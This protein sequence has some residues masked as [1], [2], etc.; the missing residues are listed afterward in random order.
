[1]N[2]PTVHGY[3]QLANSY[4]FF[5]KLM[6]GS[7][8][9]NARTALLNSIPACRSALILGDGNGRL[10]DAL[11]SSQPECE[12]TSIDQSKKMLDIQQQ[13]LS[14]H[15]LRGNVTWRH[16]D[17]RSFEGFENQFDLLVSAFFLDCFTARDL[18][19]HLPRWLNSLRPGG[20]FYFVDFQEPDSGWKRM[21]GKLCLTAMHHFFRWQTDLPNRTLVNMNAALDQCALEML[22]SQNMSH[23]LIC[24]RLYRV[25][26]VEEN[27]RSQAGRTQEKRQHQSSEE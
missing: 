17:A 9:E 24:T 27:E 6:F 23:D 10:L 8:L 20:L 18:E 15:P 21:R 4:R 1:M 16:Q 11:L 22:A 2:N 13:R 5:E 26:T 3:D 19:T 12:I 25:L 14:N 7:D